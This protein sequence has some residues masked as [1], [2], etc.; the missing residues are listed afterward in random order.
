MICL[1]E[2]KI[3]IICKI[4]SPDGSSRYCERCPISNYCGMSL[5]CLSSEEWEIVSSILENFKIPS[6][7]EAFKVLCKDSSVIKPDS[8]IAKTLPYDVFGDAV[9]HENTLWAAPISIEFLNKI[10]PDF[11][12]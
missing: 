7:A 1:D 8:I 3:Q 2:K 12:E 6:Y 10:F 11:K 5:P 9:K 4:Y